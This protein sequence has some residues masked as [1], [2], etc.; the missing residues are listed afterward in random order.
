MSLR[1]R[2]RY[3]L[4]LYQQGETGETNSIGDPI[5]DWV[6]QWDTPVEAYQPSMQSAGGTDRTRGGLVTDADLVC[7]TSDPGVRDIDAGDDHCV[8][9][10]PFDDATAYVIDRVRPLIGRYGVPD[11][12]ELHCKADPANDVGAYRG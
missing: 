5:T 11:E 4:E 8:V 3:T 7:H 10:D 2:P 6:L 12:W 9:I 1:S